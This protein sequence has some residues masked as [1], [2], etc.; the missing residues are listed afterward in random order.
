MLFQPV[1]KGQGMTRELSRRQIWTSICLSWVENFPIRGSST[2]CCAGFSRHYM[3]YM[4]CTLTPQPDSSLWRR[5]RL[6]LSQEETGTRSL[7]LFTCAVHQQGAEA[8][9]GAEG[10]TLEDLRGEPRLCVRT[11]VR[12]YYGKLASD[13]F[14]WYHHGRGHVTYSRPRRGYWMDVRN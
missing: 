8:N 2:S 1:T 4:C 3:C 10:Q 7:T 12:Q 5:K 13:P 6:R 11:S 9:N 14:M